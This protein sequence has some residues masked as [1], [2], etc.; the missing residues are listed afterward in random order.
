M[1]QTQRHTVEKATAKQRQNGQTGPEKQTIPESLKRVHKNPEF[2]AKVKRGKDQI[3]R[4]RNVRTLDELREIA[5]R[6]SLVIVCL[7]K[8]SAGDDREL[9]PSLLF[10]RSFSTPRSKRPTLIRLSP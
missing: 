2:W 9:V 10:F 1:D 8:L 6:A 3:A 5:A 7:G 4:A